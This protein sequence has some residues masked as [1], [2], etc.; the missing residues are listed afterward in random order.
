MSN[1]C[2]EPRAKQHAPIKVVT[3]DLDD[4]MWETSYVL[5]LANDQLDEF[6]R[7][8]YPQVHSELQ[9]RCIT[10]QNL[11]EQA[12]N[13]ERNQEPTIGEHPTF[14]SRLRKEALR[15]AARLG[16]LEP[17]STEEFVDR[18]YEHWNIVRSSVPH[19]SFF[20]GVLNT[21]RQLQERG[22]RLAG[23]TN[24]TTRLEFNDALSPL[25]SFLVNAEDTGTRKPGVEPFEAAVNR[26]NHMGWT[27]FDPALSWVHVGDDVESDCV[28]A[29]GCGWR[30][31]LVRPPR[32]HEKNASG[33]VNMREKEHMKEYIDAE[34]CRFEDILHVIDEWNGML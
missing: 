3:F 29:K 17:L 20:P 31:I 27:E 9:T 19:H 13:D 4:T 15:R 12:W 16:G 10:V 14:L 24:G 6:M 2:N 22:I 32:W 11:V 28:G 25:L 33:R 30:T 1:T 8:E 21:L 18:T 23:I 34:C 26:A 7:D 5:G